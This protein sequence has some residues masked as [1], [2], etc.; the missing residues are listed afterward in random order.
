MFFSTLGLTEN[1]SWP[2]W[3]EKFT[4]LNELIIRVVP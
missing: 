2:K 4:T 1:Y 3:R